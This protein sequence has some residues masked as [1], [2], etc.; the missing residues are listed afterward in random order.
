MRM[1]DTSRGRECIAPEVNRNRNIGEVGTNMNKQ[2]FRRYLSTMGW[3]T[4]E[5]GRAGQGGA[6]AGTAAGGLASRVGREV[7]VG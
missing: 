5:V 4:E 3:S 6:A 1:E 7:G 2:S